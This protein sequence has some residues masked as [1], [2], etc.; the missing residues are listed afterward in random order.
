[1][2]VFNA[3]RTE[4]ASNVANILTFEPFPTALIDVNLF[5]DIMNQESL[6]LLSALLA[7]LAAFLQLTVLLVLKEKFFVQ[8]NLV[9]RAALRELTHLI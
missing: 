8:I 2:T 4:N 1:M 9:L 3:L 5:W 7:V 6:L